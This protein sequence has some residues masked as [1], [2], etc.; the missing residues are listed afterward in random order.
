MKEIF[1]GCHTW[2]LMSTCEC[3]LLHHGEAFR[4]KDLDMDSGECTLDGNVRAG[5]V[6][7]AKRTSSRM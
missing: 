7:L 2:N 6:R 3:L 4:E 5:L 1:L